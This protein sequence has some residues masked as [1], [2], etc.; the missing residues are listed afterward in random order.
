MYDLAKS[1]ATKITDSATITLDGQNM[2]KF[3]DLIASRHSDELFQPF[4]NVLKAQSGSIKEV[5][6]TLGE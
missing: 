5:S 3:R 6:T 1:S 2:G 4:H